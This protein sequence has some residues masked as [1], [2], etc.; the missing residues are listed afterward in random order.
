MLYTCFKLST[1]YPGLTKLSYESLQAIYKSS[2]LW[3]HM[4]HVVSTQMHGGVLP[5]TNHQLAANADCIGCLGVIHVCEHPPFRDV[6][7]TIKSRQRFGKV[8]R[9]LDCS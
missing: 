2:L 5:S 3:H 1:L 9:G 4:L 6:R 8:I 7:K